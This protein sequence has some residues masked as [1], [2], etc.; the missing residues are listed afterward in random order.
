MQEP[1]KGAKWPFRV[2][3]RAFGFT[4]VRYRVL[5][6]N[7]ERLCAG[8]ALVKPLPEA[9][10]AGQDK[11]ANG[12][13]KGRSVS[14]AGRMRPLAD[15]TDSQTIRKTPFKPDTAQFR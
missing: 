10:A 6:R 5:K 1:Y 8:F 12:P 13:P 3:K 11:P 2:L 14:A 9:Q 15:K 7:H 4:Q